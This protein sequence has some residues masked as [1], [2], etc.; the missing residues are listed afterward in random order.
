METLTKTIKRLNDEQFQEL[1]SEVAPNKQ[2]KP[3]LVLEAARQRELN[4]SQM[5]EY[6]EVNPNTYYTLKSRLSTKIASVL[7]KKVVN[8]ISILMQEV[9]RVPANLYG[10]NKQVAIRALKELEK[11]LIEYDMSNELITVY[12]TLA[13]LYMYNEQEHEHYSRLHDKYVAFSLAGIKAENLFY[14]FILKAGKYEL[15]RQ[16]QDLDAVQDIVRKLSNIA[17][18]YDSHRLYVFYNII[19]IYHIC[20]ISEDNESIQSRE[21]EIDQTLKNIQ[22]IFDK[23][24]L[25]TL[26]NNIRFMVAFL[27]FEYYQKCGYYVRARHYYEKVKDRI[28]E[29]AG[30]HILSF[31]VIRFLQSKLEMFLTSED[32]NELTELNDTLKADLDIDKEEIY[33]YVFL[34]RYFAISKFYER[35]YSATAKL[36][37]KLR[38]EAYLKPYH[39][40]DMDIKMFQALQYCLMRDADL[41][42]Q[43]LNSVARQSKE[44]DGYENID[45]LIKFIRASFKDT[46]PPK[47]VK[48]LEYLWN[49]FLAANKGQKRILEYVRLNETMLATMAKF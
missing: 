45:I 16:K 48:R 28:P 19:R 42:K 34:N 24:P 35:E 3:Y 43:M 25:D 20:M 14:D 22:A 30:Q 49:Q 27:Y 29:L 17:E 36:L 1:L 41:A 32:I 23:Y 39:H 26:Y 38:H 47:K 18:L 13:R 46:D 11:Q 33:Q 37:N 6:L 10:N 21:I 15:T 44:D 9:A 5:I 8:P 7:S 31:H 12:K 40:I 4:D 2:S